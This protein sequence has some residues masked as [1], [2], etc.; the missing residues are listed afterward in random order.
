MDAQECCTVDPVARQAA[1]EKRDERDENDNDE[2]ESVKEGG[3]RG[4]RIIKNSKQLFTEGLIG[5]VQRF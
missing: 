4:A 5:L 1:Q 2:E 3:R